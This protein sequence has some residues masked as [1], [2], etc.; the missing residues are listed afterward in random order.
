MDVQGSENNFNYLVTKSL[1]DL[2]TSSE[3]LASQEQICRENY[4]GVDRGIQTRLL[5]DRKAI[6][7]ALLHTDPGVRGIAVILLKNYWPLTSETAQ[8]A[9]IEFRVRTSS[10]AFKILKAMLLKKF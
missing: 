4:I 10:K 3:L 6:D 8:S 2:E 7:Q 9:A 5:A 1:L